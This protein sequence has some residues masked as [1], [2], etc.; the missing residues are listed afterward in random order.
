[1]PL[2][3]YWDM[4]IHFK[5]II[6]TKR[7]LPLAVHSASDSCNLSPLLD[8][9]MIL[10]R[11]VCKRLLFCCCFRNKQMW[12][13]DVQPNLLCY[14]YLGITCCLKGCDPQRMAIFRLLF[15]L[16]CG[17]YDY[18][19]TQHRCCSTW[20]NLD[21]VFS[22]AV[23]LPCAIWDFNCLINTLTNWIEWKVPN[24]KLWGA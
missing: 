15:C 14:C 21:S 7:L 24:G 1:M 23:D 11:L 20:P 12:M 3:G 6:S 22:P 10:Q 5:N 19:K 16:S 17:Q 8:F 18:Y 2:V 4:V 9:T 13:Y